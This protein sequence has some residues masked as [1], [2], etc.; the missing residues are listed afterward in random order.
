[1][2]P[3]FG[4]GRR[5]K[6]GWRSNGQAQTE[7]PGEQALEIEHIYVLKAFHGIGLCKVLYQKALDPA[8]QNK[9][10]CLSLGVWEKNHRAIRFYEK[11]GFVAFDQHIFPPGGG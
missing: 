11:N 3:S 4:R 8:E 6:K 7:R 5:C 2:P 1:M 10:D 9:A